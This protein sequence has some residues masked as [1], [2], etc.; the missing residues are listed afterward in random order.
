M[1][2]EEREIAAKKRKHREK[3]TKKKVKKT[4]GQKAENDFLLGLIG[5]ARVTY[6]LYWNEAW[7]PFSFTRLGSS[8]PSHGS[9][10]VA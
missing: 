1:L 5:Y 7:V 2:A 8:V 3:Q 4:F 9:P 10:L 6:V